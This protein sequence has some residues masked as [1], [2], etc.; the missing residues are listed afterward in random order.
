MATPKDV[1][2]EE[3]TEE[4][5]AETPEEETSV[6]ES[7]TEEQT[8]LEEA[9]E[10]TETP[11]KAEKPSETEELTEEEKK[12]L[13]VKATKRFADLSKK[14]KRADELEKEVGALRQAQEATFTAGIKP[15]TGA[16]SPLPQ[17]PGRLPWEADLE[18]GKPVELSPED[19]KRD[20]LATADWIV[21]A[22]LGQADK[23][24][25]I[26]DDLNNIQKKYDVLNPDSDR[27]EKDFSI[28][29][30]GLFQNQLKAN[31]NVKLSDF[32]GTIMEVRQGGKEE[33]TAETTAQLAEQ[34]AEEALTPGEP[35]L[36]SIEK[37]FEE[38]DLDEK[39][40]YLKDHGLWE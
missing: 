26:K 25:E 13:S 6:T 7:S 23:A 36:E 18:E 11:E 35:E 22:R 24:S 20:V 5:L 14:A 3:P 19:Y 9:P 4:N 29:L 28:K 34:K 15:E 31:P 8:A 37:S 40:K 21:R 30:A 33:G 12:K 27:Y 2:A 39:E 38:M 32:V 17:A 1:T 16:V 10:V